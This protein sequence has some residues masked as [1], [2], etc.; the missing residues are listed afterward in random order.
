MHQAGNVAAWL[1]FQ[2]ISHTAADID[3]DGIEQGENLVGEET[4]A[5]TRDDH[6]GKGA[7]NVERYS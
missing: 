3:A 5:S 2:S 1:L 7:T 4:T 6:V